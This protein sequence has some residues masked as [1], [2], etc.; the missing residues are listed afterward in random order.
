MRKSPGRTRSSTVVPEEVTLEVQNTV[1][2]LQMNK[3][4]FIHK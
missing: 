3:K 2:Q 4:I 1:E